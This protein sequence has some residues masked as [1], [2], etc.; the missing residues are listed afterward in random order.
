MECATY[1]RTAKDQPTAR[2]LAKVAHGMNMVRH[3]ACGRHLTLNQP[4]TAL[5]HFV[6][7]HPMLLSPRQGGGR[8]WRACAQDKYLSGLLII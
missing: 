8:R 3:I 2:V 5:V 1:N 4:S 7:A 6:W